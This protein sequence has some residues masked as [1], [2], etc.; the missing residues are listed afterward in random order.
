MET[1]F[2]N[3]TEIVGMAQNSALGNSARTRY[4]LWVRIRGLWLRVYSRHCILPP[5]TEGENVEVGSCVHP[6]YGP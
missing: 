1:I 2:E 4:T 6:L 3:R 5:A